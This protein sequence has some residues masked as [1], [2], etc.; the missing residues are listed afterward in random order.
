[1]DLYSIVEQKRELFSIIGKW[2]F[3]KIPEDSMLDL[4]WYHLLL[5]HKI[6]WS[7]YTKIDLLTYAARFRNSYSIIRELLATTYYDVQI[8][9]NCVKLINNY[10][11]TCDT[12]SLGLGPYE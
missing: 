2:V 12:R 10:L 6:E 3:A 8:L 11:L 9:N 5:E 7:L 4:Y 1:M